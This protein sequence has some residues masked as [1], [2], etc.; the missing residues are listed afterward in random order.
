MDGESIRQLGYEAVPFSI[1]RQQILTAVAAF[2]DFL[3]LPPS[4]K[5]RIDFHVNPTHRRSEI[6]YRFRRST[7]GPFRDDKEFFHYH[8]AIHERYPEFLDSNPAVERFCALARPVFEAAV[9]TMRSVVEQMIEPVVPGICQRIFDVP[10]PHVQLRFLRYFWQ[11][12]GKN[13]AKGHYDCGLATLAIAESGPGL[14]IGHDDASLR[15]VVHRDREAVFMVGRS[16]SRFPEMGLSPSW[17]DVVQSGD[18]VSCEP[19]SRWAVVCF[20]EVSGAVSFDRHTTHQ[21]IVRPVSA[22]SL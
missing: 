13:L 1:P 4:T 5:G 14:R 11:V 21:P 3:E 7:D 15:P 17:H 22:P 20:M 8:P 18:T 12:P 9:T 2:M 10:L 19:L 16:M 6:G